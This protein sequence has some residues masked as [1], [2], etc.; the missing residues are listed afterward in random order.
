MFNTQLVNHELNS[1]FDVDLNGG[2]LLFAPS[3]GQLSKR[4]VEEDDNNLYN[5]KRNIE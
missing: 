4:L 5:H 3:H 1:Y 2:K